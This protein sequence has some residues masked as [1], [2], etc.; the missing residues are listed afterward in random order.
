MQT[1]KFHLGD[2]L[3]VIMHRPVSPRG[4]DGMCDLLKFMLGRGKDISLLYLEEGCNKCRPRL[5]E[6][7]PQFATPEMHITIVKLVT[8]IDK[9]LK[10]R[11]GIFKVD[12]VAAD[13]LLTQVATFGEKLVVKPIP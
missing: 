6:Q 3:S 2:V 9:M 8:E 5:L 10:T 12:K 13:W 7:F 4:I 1:R 11:R